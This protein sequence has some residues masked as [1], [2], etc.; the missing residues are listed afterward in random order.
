MSDDE[1]PRQLKREASK[2]GKTEREY[3]LSRIK[4]WREML[5]RVSDDFTELSDEEF[6]IRYEE[7]KKFGDDV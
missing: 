4:Y 1:I 3:C 2:A 7:W 6:E 5:V